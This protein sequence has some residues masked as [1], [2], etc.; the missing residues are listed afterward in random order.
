M[1]IFQSVS[2]YITKMVSTGDSTTTSSAGAAK[3]KILLLDRDTVPIV[4]AATTQS[5]LLNHSVYLTDRIENQ[6]R[7]K[8]RH[9]RC[10]CFLRPS[11]DSIQMLID[12]LREPRYGE[13]YICMCMT[14]WEWCGVC[15][16][17]F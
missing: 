2:G 10:L 3:M 15:G 4:S 11:S 13:Y 6:E 1:D 17:M 9:L 7:E 5:A 8:M 16:R 12:E 14:F